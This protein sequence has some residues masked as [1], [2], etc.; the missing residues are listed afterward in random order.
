[1]H[2]TLLA[3]V[4]KWHICKHIIMPASSYTTCLTL[5]GVV[6]NLPN[7]WGDVELAQLFARY[8]MVLECRMLHNGDMTRGA[9]ALV[10]MGSVQQATAAIDSLNNVSNGLGLPLLVRSAYTAAEPAWHLPSCTKPWKAC[11]A[12]PTRMLPSIH[13]FLKKLVGRSKI[14]A[15]RPAWTSCLLWAATSKAANRLSTMQVC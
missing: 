9:G 7:N 5:P 14:L 3:V 8:G 2:M 11:P 12:R 15:I 4:T 10:R 1:M 13:S 6:Q